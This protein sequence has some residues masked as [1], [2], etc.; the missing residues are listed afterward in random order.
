MAITLT[1]RKAAE[2]SGLSIRSLQYAIANGE[3]R[4][5]RVRGR[6]LVPVRAL[7]DF[8]LRGGSKPQPQSRGAQ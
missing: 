3:L 7:E 2:E 6:R 4:S 8:L 1:L 5:V